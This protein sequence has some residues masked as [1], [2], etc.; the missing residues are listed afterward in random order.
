M[1]F[2]VAELVNNIKDSV[3]GLL[4]DLGFDV[5]GVPTDGSPQY[6]R[7]K[8]FK[9]IQTDTAQTREGFRK[10]ILPYTFDVIDIENPT[11][12][13]NPFGPFELPLAPQQLTLDQSPAISIKPTQGGTT[14]THSGV[15]Y[16]MLM[17]KGTTGIAPF[18]GAGGVD[19]RTGEAILQPKKLKFKSGYE[20]FHHL[21]NYI[22]TYYEYKKVQ[23]ARAANLRLVFKNYKDGQF[24]IIENLKFTMNRQ[25]G[26]PFLYDYD[27]QFK[28][29]AHFD[30]SSPA[31]DDNILNQIDNLLDDAN[32]ILDISRGVMLRSQDILRQIESTYNSVIIEPLR[33]ISLI[34]KAAQGIGLVAGDIGSRILRNTMRPADTQAILL[35]VQ[36]AQTQAKVSPD[37]DSRLVNA[38]LPRDIGDAV[39]TSGTETID[40]LGEG[41]MA[42]DLS[43]FPEATRNEVLAEQEEL[44][45]SP[46]SF[47]QDTLNDLDRVKANLE[48]F[49]NLGSSDY[50]ALFGRVST[51]NA[52]P[53]KTVTDAELD[54]LSSFNQAKKAIQRMLSTDRLFKSQYDA[55]IQD[56]VE[57]F[58]N[59]ITLIANTAVIQIELNKGDTLARLAQDYL[60]DSTRWGEIVE[61]NNLRPPYITSDFQ[62]TDSGVLKVGDKILIPVP[63]QSGF[64]QV[65]KGAENKLTEGLTELEKSLGV[66]FKVDK[67]F[68]LV[69]SNSGDLELVAGAD[70]MAQAVIIKLSYEKGDVMG[71]PTIGSGAT[72]G[73]KFPPLQEIKDDLVRTLLQDNRIE[74]VDGLSLTQDNSE[75]SLNFNLKIK[76]VDIP[77]PISIK[78]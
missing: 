12:N 61:V 54:L 40:N 28:V 5:G 60:G 55:R 49:V 32:R 51:L 58:R 47:F 75:L 77:I 33:K 19:R 31:E 18:R 69:L 20:V 26:R 57:R 34:L 17:I 6:P 71:H 38:S 67:N 3:G 39:A 65:P 66:D 27:L 41:L 63:Q 76:Q 68:D 42:L 24:L 4:N 43:E 59:D 23:G 11:S 37:V 70:N 52:D 74:R 53:A 29:L 25:A 21:N 22:N 15:R 13:Q 45:N 56:I 73:K 2:G 78:V 8:E 72:P 46:R 10:L 48:D 16:K 7:D 62:S 50:D 9:N 36:S 14:T 44:A 64:S 30:F 35:N 1:A